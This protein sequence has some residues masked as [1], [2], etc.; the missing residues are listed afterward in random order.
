MISFPHCKI[1]LGLN[2]IQK[3][4]DGFHNIESVFYPVNWCDVLEIIEV[5]T[6]PFE[7]TISG[8]DVKG[9]PEKNLCYKAWKLISLDFKLPNLSV[10]LHKVLPMGAGL[11]GGSSD[12]AFTLKMINELCNLGLSTEKLVEY[13]AQIGS[14]CAFFIHNK[15]M[16]ATGKGEILA[17]L[18]VNLSGHKIV[19]AMPN[20]SVGTAE[21]YS[22]IKPKSPINNL[23]SVLKSSINS[24]NQNLVNDFEIPV[25]ERFPIIGEIKETF[26][27]SGAAYTSMSG[28]GAAVF[29]LFEKEIPKN[30]KFDSQEVLIWKEE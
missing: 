21:A 18:D 23:E 22:W 9:D 7:L 12:A 11:G 14:D 20:V 26:K 27:T 3:R 4:E 19:I 29:A 17:P 30:L 16:L 15:P 2:V 25:I 10:Y 5:G 8:L 6:K 13:A 28:S 1:N 24:W